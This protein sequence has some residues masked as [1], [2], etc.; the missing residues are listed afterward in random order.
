MH[1]ENAMRE[2]R[3]SITDVRESSSTLK[4]NVS[5]AARSAQMPK[6]TSCCG[7]E[8]ACRRHQVATRGRGAFVTVIGC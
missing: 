3:M 4:V 1:A 8:L 5:C 2:A 6:R 7:R